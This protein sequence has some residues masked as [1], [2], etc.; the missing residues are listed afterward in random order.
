MAI[1]V[2]YDYPI[3]GRR[4]SVKGSLG[5]GKTRVQ[6]NEKNYVGLPVVPYAPNSAQITYLDANS[7]IDYGPQILVCDAT[8]ASFSIQLP[9]ASGCLGASITVIKMD[10]T[11]NTISFT[12]E[13]PSVLKNYVTW[14]SLSK[15]YETVI[16]LAIED[17]LSNPMWIAMLSKPVV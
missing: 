15:Q 5:P 10:S 1:P 11:V 7:V 9:Q 4:G 2:V 16:W 17:S 3:A 13:T 6:F 8:T 14:S 12:T